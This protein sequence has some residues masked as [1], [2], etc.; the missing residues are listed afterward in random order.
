MPKKPAKFVKGQKLPYLCECE[1]KLINQMPVI[2][3]FLF[4]YLPLAYI[5]IYGYRF[6]I[7][8]YG[9]MLYN[10]VLGLQGI[11]VIASVG[12]AFL[13]F[14]KFFKLKARK[15]NM[16]TWLLAITFGVFV[17]LFSKPF[18]PI[19]NPENTIKSV[20]VC[21]NMSEDEVMSLPGTAVDALVRRVGP[22]TER[23][24]N[25][26]VFDYLTIV[27]R[28]GRY[29]GLGFY[30]DD[31]GVITDIMPLQSTTRGTNWFRFLPFYS[32]FAST[33]LFNLCYLGNTSDEWYEE[34]FGPTVLMLF[35]CFALYFAIAAVRFNS[36]IKISE[37]KTPNHVIEKIAIAV[38]VILVYAAMLP[39]LNL[40]HSVWLI[41][42]P[43][44]LSCTVMAVSLPYQTAE[45]ILKVCPEC[46]QLDV[47]NPKK[48]VI[49]RDVKPYKIGGLTFLYSESSV[50]RWVA[51]KY[52]TEKEWYIK[53]GACRNCG[54]HDTNEYLSE[55][56]GTTKKCPYCDSELIVS[57]ENI[58]ILTGGTRTK[59]M[60]DA[61]INLNQAE[62]LG[63]DTFRGPV[64][65][66]KQT[67]TTKCTTFDYSEKCPNCSYKYGPHNFMVSYEDSSTSEVRENREVK[68]KH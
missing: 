43:L 61:T 63:H 22:P 5:S 14:A 57:H 19:N 17:L 52:Y 32:T 29:R 11:I 1:H 36:L 60:D 62:Q 46:H 27:S 21:Y 15:K 53:E 66:H 37:G 16:V 6:G 4:L 8:I 45:E 26:L 40:T 3:C 59:Y 20:N 35:F 28:D 42:L 56:S 49:R 58:K 2:L 33:N 23:L 34:A 24:T 30:V 18:V 48:K 9:D 54:Y 67:F 47:Y 38:A 44:Y 12:F 55:G 13:V 68:L 50:R 7:N 31:E 65:V 51:D 39:Y 10:L 64:T 41:S 25:G